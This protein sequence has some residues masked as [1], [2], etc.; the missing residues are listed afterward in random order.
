[1]TSRRPGSPRWTDCERVGV[2]VTIQ[3]AIVFVPGFQGCRL[4]LDQAEIWPPS[5]IELGTVYGRMRK[6]LTPRTTATSIVDAVCNGRHEVY[7][8][9][10]DLLARLAQSVGG[11]WEPFAFDWRQDNIGVSADRLAEHLR[12]VST[13]ADNITLVAHSMGGIVSRIVLESDRSRFG[14]AIRRVRSFVAIA[15]PHRGA[16]AALAGALAQLRTPALNARQTRELAADPRYP[17]HYQLLPEHGIDC[18]FDPSG[19]ELDIYDPAVIR[20]YGLTS[21]NVAAARRQYRA[22][23]LDDR[24]CEYTFIAADG[25]DTPNS[26]HDLGGARFEVRSTKQEGDGFVPLW[27]STHSKITSHR[28]AGNHVADLFKNPAFVDVLTEVVWGTIG[29]GKDPRLDALIAAADRASVS[30]ALDSPAYDAGTTMG[31]LLIG[32]DAAAEPAGAFFI[33][34]LSIEGAPAAERNGQPVLV[35]DRETL[36]DGI[37]I[38][39]PAAPGL[40]RLSYRATADGAVVAVD[41]AVSAR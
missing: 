3:H 13:R 20:T 30:I 29:D 31:V 36:L 4:K 22:L 10:L 11:L 21:D 25:L 12:A 5:N 39:A 32:L 7:G 9:L 16:P 33:D 24:P 34:P 40:Y 37:L 27:S 15:T 35:L 8:K 38:P 14:N 1:M 23:D 6:L 18:L 26:V 28:V 41:F 19:R 2:P 17:S